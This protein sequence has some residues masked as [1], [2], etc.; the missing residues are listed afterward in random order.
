[1]FEHAGYK[2][3]ADKVRQVLAAEGLPSDAVDT[4]DTNSP[5]PMPEPKP[6]FPTIES[7]SLLSSATTTTTVVVE[8]EYR[9]G[10]F[11]LYIIYIYIYITVKFMVQQPLYLE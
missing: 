3:Y 5:K 1:M 2:D 4:A 10:I 6:E 11:S 9:Q 8:K 7:I